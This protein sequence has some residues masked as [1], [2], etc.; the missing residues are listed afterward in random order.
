MSPQ[1]VLVLVALFGGYLAR[2]LGR[3]PENA[4]DVL[5]R[6]VIDVCLPAMILR[7]LPALKMRW[8][9]L[10][11]VITPWTLAA[12]AWL[13]S[14]LLARLC[15][16]DRAT[17]AALF[18]CLAL[19]NTSF[20]G[21]PLCAAV[22]GEEAIPLAAVYDQLGSF[23]MLCT[24]APVVLA[25][26]SGA[27]TIN[28]R[29]TVGK[30]LTFPPFL[31]L[32]LSL[33]PL[34]AHPAWLDAVLQAL[35]NALVPVAMFAVGLRLRITPPPQRLA[36]GLGLGIKLLLLPACALGISLLAGAS[37]MVRAVAVLESAMPAMITAGAL[38]MSAGIAP[39]LAAAL[40]GYGIL[41]A[42]VTVPLWGVLLRSL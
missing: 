35:S 25:R 37:G 18:L 26:A 6:F 28:P 21:F 8:D 42:Q 5:N 33:L 34:P 32:L 3:F 12:I 22:L 36:F 24:I 16:F 20:L 38:A 9:V 1:L 27:R 19:G 40:V 2:R 23:L 30:V 39:E 14:R 4:S 13:L 31:A 11:L 10:V 29:E 7:V 15:R 41:L 17:S